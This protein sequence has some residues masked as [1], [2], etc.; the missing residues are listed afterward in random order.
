MKVIYTYT[1]DCEGIPMLLLKYR[2]KSH[3]GLP[4]H[5]CVIFPIS[6]LLHMLNKML[7]LWEIMIHETNSIMYIQNVPSPFPKESRYLCKGMYGRTH[8]SY[9]QNIMLENCKHMNLNV[10]HNSHC[11]SHL[12]AK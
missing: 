1:H 3:I 2:K 9:R 4:L 11:M 6:F 8:T 5:T 12:P 7:L 10:F